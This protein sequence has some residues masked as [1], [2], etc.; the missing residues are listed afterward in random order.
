[1]LRER[2]SA[3]FMDADAT[4]DDA[5]GHRRGFIGLVDRAIA[6]GGR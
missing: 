6:L 2:L 3:A 5:A 1:M 4:G